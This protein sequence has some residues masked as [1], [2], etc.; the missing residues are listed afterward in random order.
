MTGLVFLAAFAALPIVGAGPILSRRLS[1][2][3]FGFAVTSAASVGAVILGAEMFVSTL[4]GLRWTL[5]LLLAAP[6]IAIAVALRRRGT[7]PSQTGPLPPS[8]MTPAAFGMLGIAAAAVAVVAYAAMT[9]RI[10]SSDL[11]LF[12]GAKGEQFGLAGRIDYDFLGRA[13]HLLMHADYPPLWPCLYA[14]A[15]MAAGRFA[16]GASLATLPFFLA[17][18]T[19]SMWS[20]GRR[21]LGALEAAG[22][23][24]AFAAMFGFLLLEGLT[25]GNADAPLLF[26]EALTLCLLVFAR[27]E[28]GVFL[29]AGIAL[30][31]A[32]WLKLEG[33]AF[34]WAVIAAAAVTIRP[35]SARKLAPLALPPLVAYGAWMIFCRTHDLLDTLGK[36]TWV[37]TGERFRSIALG[38]VRAASMESSYLPWVL[39]ALLFAVR[40]PGRAAV[41]AV[42]VAALI[43]AFD[44]GFYLAA[45]SDPAVWIA[46]A[47]MRTLMTPLLALLLAAMAP[48]GATASAE[49][50]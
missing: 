28:P 42:L 13:D 36:H 47:G 44:G 37:L 38:M 39:V 20:I 8:R 41:F 12:W 27:E 9:A 4:V 15:T 3:P 25:A 19:V 33:I 29:L 46:M 18:G 34:G 26:F 35:F 17:L 22:L 21:R 1:W 23:A 30:A 10:T 14:F 16:W 2:L 11:L 31:G 32:A 48:G 5:G 6:A 24:A 7:S 40:R 45:G 49:R 50:R 43:A